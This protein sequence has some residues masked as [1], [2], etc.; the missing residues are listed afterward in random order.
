MVAANDEGAAKTVDWRYGPFGELDPERAAIVLA[1]PVRGPQFSQDLAQLG[2]MLLGWRRDLESRGHRVAAR[3]SGQLA[4][5]NRVPS[6]LVA[7]L[8]TLPETVPDLDE[9]A[10]RW[11]AASHGVETPA[12]ARRYL[13][14]LH[15]LASTATEAGAGLYSYAHT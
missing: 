11:S 5:V 9:L 12:Y 1:Q 2:K 15:S 4:V 8:A 10:G 13:D 6:D 7:A 14:G 3:R